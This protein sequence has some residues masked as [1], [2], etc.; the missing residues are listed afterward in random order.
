MH[1][2]IKLAQ[3]EP[4]KNYAPHIKKFNLEDIKVDDIKSVKQLL[5]TRYPDIHISKQNTKSIKNMKRHC[6]YIRISN[7]TDIYYFKLYDKHTGKKLTHSPIVN[8]IANKFKIH[9]VSDTLI[10]CNR[11]GNIQGANRVTSIKADSIKDAIQ[12]YEKRFK[13]EHIKIGYEHKFKET[14]DR[15]NMVEITPYSDGLIGES[16]YYELEI[17]S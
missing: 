14:I 3:L 2:F 13:S 8:Y 16:S 1:Y 6:L 10:P 17:G 7:N 12:E 9:L 11:G 5:E 15:H 4:N